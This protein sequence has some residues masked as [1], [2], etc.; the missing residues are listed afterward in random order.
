[1]E[2]ATQSKQAGFTERIPELDGLRGIAIGSVL[3][4]HCFAQVIAD[5]LRG[6]IYPLTVPGRG[7]WAGVDLFFVLS[8]FLIGG[9]LLDSRESTNYFK[10]FYTRRFFRIVPAYLALLV[11]YYGISAAATFGEIPQLQ[12]E[13]AWS[14]P[15]YVLVLFLHNFWVAISRSWYPLP[16]SILWSLAVEEQFYLTLP[17]LVRFQKPKRAM[18]IALEC[19]FLAICVRLLCWKLMNVFPT[20]WSVLMPCRMDSLLL[21]FVGAVIWRDEE[22]RARFARQKSLHRVLLLALASGFPVLAWRT[23]RTTERWGLTIGLTWI[24]AF[25]FCFLMYA[26][27]HKDGILG[28]FLRR[29]WLGWLGGIAYGVYL[30]HRLIMQTFSG[31][32]WHW[33]GDVQIKTPWQLA[34]HLLMMAGMLG[35]CKLLFVYY[36]KPFLKRGHQVRYEFAEMSEPVVAKVEEA[37]ASVG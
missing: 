5:P 32:V 23:D 34:L 29:K 30:F 3:Y 26:M 13:E 19:V 4:F 7:G 6:W 33:N 8:G 9:I 27:L 15:W 37:T 24:A 20:Y 11:A 21:G 22:W 16:L 18:R 25:Q 28:W 2:S 35:F 14:V 12:W 36:E 31:L 10:V 17:W 1:M